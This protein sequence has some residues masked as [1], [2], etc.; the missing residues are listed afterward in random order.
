MKFKHKLPAIII[1]VL[2][3]IV[4]VL[5]V[6]G[7]GFKSGLFPESNIIL[8]TATFTVLGIAIM[9]TLT[10]FLGNL[11]D[12]LELYKLDKKKAFDVIYT[13]LMICIVVGGFIT[14]FFL[15][16]NSNAEISGQ[17]SLYE[18]AVIGG[19]NKVPDNG[20]LSVTFSKILSGILLFTGNRMSIAYIFSAV[21]SCIFII[22]SAIA[23]KLLLGKTAS[24]VYAGFVAFL[25]PFLESFK[26]LTLTTDPLF[27]CMFGIELLLVAIF[28]RKASDNSY[29]G[30]LCIIWY[31]IVGAVIGFMGYVDA[32]TFIAVLPLLIPV[33]ILR[34]ST[35][36]KELVRLIF[37]IAGAAISFFLMI[38]QEGGAAGFGTVIGKWYGYFFHNVN[39]YD[40]F[41][42]FA[43]FK[44]IY[45]IIFIVMSGIIVGFWK[46]TEVDKVSP[47]LLSI[48]ILFAATPVL[49]STRMSGALMLTVLFG[50]VI[51]CVASVIAMEPA[52]EEEYEPEA[53]ASLGTGTAEVVRPERDDESYEEQ[54]TD[55]ST[56]YDEEV[57][58]DAVEEPEEDAD[59]EP[60]E[61]ADEEPEEAADEE[62]EE[63]VD[64][65]AE[66]YEDEAS[67]EEESSEDIPEDREL[68]L[69]EM[70]EKM[71]AER[72][73]QMQAAPKEEEPF[74]VPEGMVLPKETEADSDEIKRERPK[75]KVP[76]FEGKI[77]LNRKDKNDVDNKDASRNT[78]SDDFDIQLEEGDDFDI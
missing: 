60:E 26:E 61:D 70:R 30:N 10:Y 22:L 43:D 49:G 73:E 3:V 77:A 51:A 68:T 21:L 65:E 23:V 46:N 13:V 38:F 7:S 16:A 29:T 78:F 1:W 11:S 71:I 31:V 53:Q 76:Q 50:F 5:M 47:I 52:D 37:V 4:N 63:D 72:E 42:T 67:E 58:E 54:E 74:F 59:E 24:L 2:F 40:A 14:R 18:N 35:V 33:L 75:K 15:L 34:N 66:E 17:R 8:Y 39:S 45:F 48:V 6:A 9:N 19:T 28:L 56:E 27:L 36:G 55:V 44:L 20:L 64:E 25:P 41:W 57:E 12:S 32:G 69:P 62:Y